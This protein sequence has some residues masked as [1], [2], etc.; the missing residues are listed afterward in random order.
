MVR[1]L[2]LPAYFAKFILEDLYLMNV[3]WKVRSVWAMPSLAGSTGLGYASTFQRLT[4]A[5]RKITSRIMEVFTS[6]LSPAR[7]RPYLFSQKHNLSL[8]PSYGKWKWE[9]KK[10]NPFSTTIIATMGFTVFCICCGG[11]P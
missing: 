3:M 7:W 5:I 2:I 6:V 10:V 9:P 4:M 1:S 11:W 8:F